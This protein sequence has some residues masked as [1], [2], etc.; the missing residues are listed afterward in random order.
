MNAY[1]ITSI[2][3]RTL[4]ISVR[5]KSTIFWT[6]LFP[7]M[8]LLVITSLFAPPEKTQSTLSIK[9]AIVPEEENNKLIELAEQ[10]SK[11]LSI[12]ENYNDTL[13]F[14][15]NAT[16]RYN[17]SDTL[18][19]LKKGYFDTII[20]IP[21]DAYLSLISNS[22]IKIRLFIL[23]SI[24]D[25]TKEQLVRSIL[26]GFFRENAHY[27]AIKNL[28]SI[29]R[30]ASTCNCISETKIEKLSR[31]IWENYDIEITNV[32]PGSLENNPRP[33]VIGW[34]L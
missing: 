29:L 3:V 22:T 2:I 7:I 9:I 30:N 21:K 20:L 18:S 24:T 10:Y 27:M 8:L 5:S 13:S 12:I 6:V 32:V 14:K 1:T 15:I 25:R 26:T 33:L 19:R 17:L 16:V 23:A 28:Y 34:I 4:K 11:Y 31:N